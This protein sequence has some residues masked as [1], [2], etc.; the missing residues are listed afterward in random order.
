[1]KALENLASSKKRG[2]K[3]V[4]LGK[5]Q[6]IKAENYIKEALKTGDWV[7]LQNCHLASKWLDTLEKICEDL[8]DSG[9]D[10]TK[11]NRDFR[12][13]LTSYP[14]DEFP[15]SILQNGVKMTNEAP[16]GLKNNLINSFNVNPISDNTFFNGNSVPGKFKKLLFGLLFF[17]AVIQERRLYGPLGWINRYEFNEPDLRISAQQLNIFMNEFPDKTPFDALHYC[18][19]ECNYGGRVTDAKDRITLMTLL[20]IYYC[21]DVFT[22]G[23]KYS[24]SGIY[25]A[26]PTG[27]MED[28]KA[29]CQTLPTFPSPE[30]F[31][32]HENG[33]IT[34][35]TGE[36]RDTLAVLLSTQGSG[37]GGADTNKD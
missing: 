6:G 36:T 35:E 23:Y 26:P 16:K 1:M 14:T 3:A 15:V 31:G 4:S 8:R 27:E 11:V 37:S 32:M 21:E 9:S 17:H 28:Y 33:S 22:E 24:P 12:L 2:L 10:L 34:K 13:W 25:F 19:G 30:V 20:K 29:Y 5:G 7:V 18:I